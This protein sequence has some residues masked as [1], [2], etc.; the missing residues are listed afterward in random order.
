MYLGMVFFGCQWQVPT[1]KL[2]DF[3]GGL[4]ERVWEVKHR[5]AHKRLTEFAVYQLEVIVTSW[6]AS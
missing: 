5:H 3:G 6:G 2:R 1:E 4:Q